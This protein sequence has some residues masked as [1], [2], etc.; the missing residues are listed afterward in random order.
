MIELLVKLFIKDRENIGSPAVRSAYGKLAG[1]VGIF[2]NA[3]LCAAKFAAGIVSGSVSITADA[4]NNLSDASSSVI[5]LIG[6]KLAE[7]NAD[8]EHPYGHGRYEYLAGFMVAALIMVIGA[9]LLRDSVLKIIAPSEVEFGVIPLVVLIFSI[10]LK[11][12]MMLFN[13]KIGERIRSETLMAACADSRNDVISTSAVLAAL[14]ISR[15]FGVQLDGIMGAAVALFIL[16][17]GAGLV[18]EAMDPLLGKAPSAEFVEEIRKKILSYN[19]ILGTHDLMIHDYGP[20]RQFASVHVEVPAEMPLVDCHEVIDKIERDFLHDGLNMLVHPDPIVSGDSAAGQINAELNKIV[21]EIDGR[22]TVHD[23]RVVQCADVKKVI[24][25]CVIPPDSGLEEA[26]LTGEI[27]RFL[28]LTA[29]DCRCIISFESSYASIPKVSD[30][31]PA[32]D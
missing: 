5:S 4:V 12:W 6:F 13:K 28:R 26:A 17:S 9:Q 25:D 27:T 22:I 24:F 18:R 10:A 20:G 7:K 29:P 2:C 16:Y 11:L 30:A 3:L 8:S 19:G 23:I 32:D 15:F 14:L 21:K 31:D 1:K